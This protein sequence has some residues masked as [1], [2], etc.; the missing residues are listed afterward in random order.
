MNSYQYKQINNGPIETNDAPMPVYDLPV[1]GYHQQYDQVPMNPPTGEQYKPVPHFSMD[2]P[3][4]VAPL[5]LQVA[6]EHQREV[7]PTRETMQLKKQPHVSNEKEYLKYNTSNEDSNNTNS[8]FDK[9]KNYIES[10]L[11]NPNMDQRCST[12]MSIIACYEVVPAIL[13][14]SAF[15]ALFTQVNVFAAIVAPIAIL[16]FLIAVGIA[17]YFDQQVE[18]WRRRCLKVAA[19]AAIVGLLVDGAVCTYLIVDTIRGSDD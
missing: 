14:F 10:K 6:P 3:T 19:A 1:S 17:F 8:F 9:V 2:D 18:K 7:S 11:F 16:L 12:Y 13:T 4:N 5:S 15:L